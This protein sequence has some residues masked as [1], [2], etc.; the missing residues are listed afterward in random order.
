MSEPLFD[1]RK[2]FG[3]TPME[4]TMQ[5]ERTLD[6]L[7]EERPVRKGIGGILVTAALLLML[8]A[9]ALA[10]TQGGL[11]WFY[12]SIFHMPTLPKNVGELIQNDIPQTAEHPLLNLA[13]QS[14]VWLPTGYDPNYPE[15]RSLE[16]LV[17]AAP[18]EPS[19]Y[20]IHPW[21]AWEEAGKPSP[22]F[23]WMDD[24][25]KQLLLFGSGTGEY[26][27]APKDMPRLQLPLSFSHVTRDEQGDV[28]CY[29]SFHIGASYMNLIRGLADP[30]GRVS[31]IY[32]D[33]SLL[34]N[35]EDKTKN[36]S[37][38]GTVTFT[39]SLPE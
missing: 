30:Q 27:L 31:L 16:I 20:E 26:F 18:K 21:D 23:E 2:L 10:A 1:R 8:C 25:K 19:A 24:P 6:G 34:W 4:F 39:V 15:G 11:N 38:K 35:R 29:Y 12:K 37:Q 32:M 13:V 5:V 3:E 9:A 36:T 14:A 17:S 33:Y 22:D 7:K 28:L